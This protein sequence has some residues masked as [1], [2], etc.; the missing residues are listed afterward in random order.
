[1]ILK[2]FF[3]MRTTKF[4]ATLA[5]CLSFVLICAPASSAREGKSEGADL[6]LGGTGTAPGEFTDLRDITFDTSNNLY[7][8]EAAGTTKDFVKAYQGIGRVQ[9]FDNSGR[10]LQQFPL[11]DDVSSQAQRVAVA[12]DDS[13]FVTFPALDLVRHYSSNGAML[14][15]YK[16]LGAMA[17]A[18]QNIAGRE[19]IAVIGW[20]ARIIGGKNSSVGGDTLTLIA[21]AAPKNAAPETVILPV[22]L[23]EV[24]DMTSDSNGH[25]FVLAAI[26][27]IYEL[28]ATGAVVRTLG[29]GSRTRAE[30]G[31]EAIH[32]VAVDSHGNVYS[33][34][35]GNPGQ[36]VMYSADGKRIVERGGQFKW[37]DTWSTH[38]SYVPLAVD[39]NDRLWAGAAALVT[40][41]LYERFHFRPAVLRTNSDFFNT[42]APGVRQS[43]ALLLGFR[44][45]IQSDL[46][47]HI[48]YQ[49]GPIAANLVIE[50]AN[51][52]LKNVRIDY[53]VYDS[54]KNLVA[55]NGSALDLQDGTEARL[56][57]NFTAPQFGWYVIEVQISSEG[58]NLQNLAS[59]FGVTP[60]YEN[61]IAL[62]TG[63]S[64]GGWEDTPRQMF[65]GLPAV[66]LHPGKGLE[67]LDA[68][69]SSAQKLGATVIV[70]LT[71]KKDD[72]TP[73]NIAPII[74]RFKGRIAWYELF[75]EPNFSWSAQEFSERA[76]TIITV[77]R[78]I[79][80]NAKIMGPSFVNIDLNGTKTWY[81]SGAGKRVDALALHDYEGHESISPEH[82]RWKFAQLRAIMAQYGDG[83]K[84][85][86]QTERAIAGVRGGLFQG[87]T[88]AIR[89]S[90][91]ADLLETLN[92]PIEHNLHYYL[93]KG[94]Y[95]A[96]PSYLWSES[97]PHPGALVMRTRYAQTHGRTYAGTL[98][99]G[100]TGNH[101]FMGLRY[102]GADGTTLV[103]RNLGLKNH[104]VNFAI[105]GGANVQIVDSWGNARQVL[106]TNG[107]ANIDIGQLPIYVRLQPGQNAIPKA[108]NWPN[109]LAT[110]AK[111]SI[112]GQVQDNSFLNNGVLETLHD[113]NPLGDTD[114]KH[115]WQGEEMK[116][117]KPQT[118][119]LRW[120]EPQTI[121][122]IILRGVRADN[123]FS[124][125]LDYDLQ[126]LAGD[127]WKTIVKARAS[128]PVTDDTQSGE[129][130]G[131]TWYDDTNIWLHEFTP[132]STRALRIVVYRTTYGFAPDETAREIVQ[133][134]W[135][136]SSPARPML[137]EIEVYGANARP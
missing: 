112:N 16:I 90:L 44:A 11:G 31:S 65:A 41:E 67:K 99:F 66:R 84:P 98:D 26:N 114:G 95:S 134:T 70:Q 62:Q 22:P 125:L 38:S 96:V 73:E 107:M 48:A 115:I 72:F 130:S 40:H 127:D 106:A 121:E 109:N 110:N 108:M 54:E 132:V 61:M 3:S 2:F 75:N 102:R 126:V 69:L 71:D 27:Q 20:D 4:I 5:L 34:T 118:I 6:V 30:D 42:K 9:K 37:A 25:L 64:A 17:I 80:P 89:L 131:L 47:D 28:D 18:R 124:A 119:E 35:W 79:D 21:P 7:T 12:D 39:N 19:R 135:G 83:D 49:S 8:L 43:S 77:I 81:E 60:R 36:V 10:F 97:G 103:L 120:A 78:S 136:N 111:I 24:S 33:M 23:R 82:W 86:W 105:E 113:K 122:A 13:V 46:P 29:S 104:E 14:R 52:R 93:N 85:I 88:Q 63:A 137:R 128:M 129:T 101:L 68:D 57:L 53:R 100:T 51:R 59:F 87:T 94:G 76:K 45:S 55:Q 15:D 1:M 50:A 117:S 116:A 123:Q 92:V 58:Q 91:H 133:S 74:T 32:S 56:P